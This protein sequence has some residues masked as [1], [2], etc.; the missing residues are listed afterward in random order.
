MTT[1][2]ASFSLSG[3][4]TSLYGVS[5]IG[6]PANLSNSGFGSN[7]SRWLTPP[8]MN[9]QMTLLALGGKCGLPSGGAHAAPGEAYPSR[10][11]MAARAS[12]VKLLARKFR[13]VNM[14]RLLPYRHEVVVI[15]QRP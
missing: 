8:F 9:S 3:F 4:W 12:P 5:P 1:T 10:W 11:S 2:R 13:R 7:V 6:L 15:Q 14:L